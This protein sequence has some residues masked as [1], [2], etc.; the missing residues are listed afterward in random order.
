MKQIKK[1][2]ICLTA[3]L[4]AFASLPIIAFAQ[5]GEESDGER[6]LLDEIKE[7]GVLIVGTSPDFPPNEFIDSTKTGQDQYVGSDIELAKYI[8]QRMG[9]DLRIEASNFDTV[10]ANLSTGQIDLAITGLA[11]TPA[12]AQSMELSI[13]YNMDEDSEASA[14]GVLIRAEDA[15]KYRT[16]EDL[17]GVKIA[18]Q[19]GSIQ[20]QYV[21]DQISDPQLQSITTIDDGVALLKNGSVNAVAT[22]MPTGIQYAQ[23]NSDLATMEEEFDISADYAGTRIGAPLG[24]KE[25]IEEVN[26][27]LEDVNEQGLYEQWYEEA[28][29][30]NNNMT[31]ITATSFLGT[32]VQIVQ[33]FWPQLLQGLLI[34]LGLAAITVFFGTLVGALFALIKLSK[35]KL[36][37]AVCTAY[38][39]LIRGTPLLLQLWLFITVFSTLSGGDMPMLVSVIIALVVNSSAYVAEI[40]RSGIQSVDK[41]QREAAKSLGMSNRN[42]MTK[43]ILP[44]AVK[45]I[46]PALGNEFV[47]M[48]KETSLASTF[49][50]GEL[51]TVNTVIKS[52]TYKSIEPLVIVGLIYFIVTFTLSKGVKYMERR[53]SVSD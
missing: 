33:S 35:N 43:I 32:L 4:L 12:R 48:V 27:I 13:G 9:V 5:E 40:I 25:L 47:M 26:I 41:G 11:Y 6:S 28:I 38:V 20:E 46:L 34:T 45:N 1:L 51:M 14:Q 49:F 30:L 3:V 17:R 10:L 31:S 24:E 21:K 42:T 50:I 8:A 18:A 37:Q 7:R 23:N 2:L 15:D 52:A 29:E 16:L 53:L 22:S 44:Q 36:V 39:E 19:S